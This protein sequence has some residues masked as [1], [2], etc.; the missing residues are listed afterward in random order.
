MKIMQVIG[1]DSSECLLVCITHIWTRS[2]FS[3]YIESSDLLLDID[4]K[5]QDHLVIRLIR[6]L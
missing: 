1:P 4:I 2:Y 3:S 6:R 5:I